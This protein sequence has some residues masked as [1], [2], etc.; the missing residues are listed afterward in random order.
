MAKVT[1]DEYRKNKGQ[2]NGPTSILNP[3]D[4]FIDKRLRSKQNIPFMHIANDVAGLKCAKQSVD[5]AMNRV[6]MIKNA[7]IEDYLLPDQMPNKC[8][9]RHHNKYLNS[10]STSA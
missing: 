3:V 8:T 7:P 10:S 6:K 9:I 5:R 4:N 1:Q 2:L